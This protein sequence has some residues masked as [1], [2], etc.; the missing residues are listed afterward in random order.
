MV[1]VYCDKCGRRVQDSDM[2]DGRA[3]QPAEDKWLCPA[4]VPAS[5]PESHKPAPRR[6]TTGIHVKAAPAR[7]S[8]A[9]PL[10]RTADAPEG[11]PEQPAP[12][13]V[14]I[15][16]VAGGALLVLAG[17]GILFMRGGGDKTTARKHDD[18]AVSSKET[19][20]TPASSETRGS[21]ST[22]GSVG[23]PAS[24]ATT[25]GP[26][27]KPAPAASPAADPAPDANALS[28]AERARQAEKEMQDFRNQRVAKMLEDHKAWFKQNPADAWTYQ[29]KLRELVASSGS[30]SAAIE[31]KRLLDELGTLPPQPD[32]LDVG[33]PESKG[34]QLV[35]DLDLAK[36]ASSITYDVDKHSEIKQPFDRVAYFLELQ[37]ANGDMQ[38]LYV[39]MDAFTDDAGKIGVPT[40]ASGARF[41]QNV[42]N[43]NVSSNVNGIVT[44]TGLTGGNIEFWPCNYGPRNSAN[45][46]NASSEAYDFGDEPAG[47]GDGH[48]SMQVHNH[49]AKQ[50]LFALNQWRSGNRADLGIGNQ[51]AGHPDWTFASSAGSYRSKRLRVLV[52]LK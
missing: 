27:A 32:R 31:A 39:S 11:V 49:D 24:P 30:A 20:H 43:M 52:H 7:R 38:Y 35:Y 5:A 16:L 50:T 1:I 33:A 4:C 21:A 6:A 12:N 8:G 18:V 36:L 48:G 2:A 13:R 26:A 47:Q 37:P 34:Y 44:G 9:V 15:A 29:A 40:A 22:P 25:S 10:P 14:A 28:L 19:L 45:V 41:Q 46:P 3:A 17:I 23:G 42:T 51:P